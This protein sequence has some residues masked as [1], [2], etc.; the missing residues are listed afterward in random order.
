MLFSD[1]EL[2]DRC[3]SRGPS[4]SNAIARLRTNQ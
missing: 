2:H 3:E 4:P 1:L